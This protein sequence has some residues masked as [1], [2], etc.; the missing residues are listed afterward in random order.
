MPKIS[1]IVPVYNVDKYLHQCVDSILSQTLTD[2]E[3]LLIDDGSTDDSGRICDEYALKDSRVKVFHKENGGVSSARNV[4]L[5]N[6]Q[7]DWV[8]FV[9]GDDWISS[10]M[11]ETLYNVALEKNVDIVYSDFIMNYDSYEEYYR[12][13]EY[14]PFKI[15]M[16]K[17]YISSVWTCLVNMIIK[18]DLF[19][20]YNLSSPTHLTYC[21][22]FW[23]SV[24]LFYFAREVYYVNRAFYI[25]RRINATSRVNNLDSRTEWDEQV[26]Y[27]ETVDFFRK[28][29]FIKNIEREL[30]WRILKG[31]QELILDVSKHDK[32]MKIYPTSHR[33][34]WSCP[35][36]NKKL[37][38]MMWLLTTGKSN[39]LD[40]LINIRN[41]LR[42]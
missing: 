2:L 32:F 36:I 9:D 29:N 26:A 15:Q 20:L 30:S 28:Q 34:I 31:K 42:R 27:L 35:F 1:I 19:E 41:F 10:D 38:V 40:I 6:A 12:V 3:L 7:C 24:R 33:Y 18:R 16:M 14:S 22:D 21:E 39:M 4:G 37:K 5:C 23:L 17:N 25:Y 11:Y 8:A 13:A